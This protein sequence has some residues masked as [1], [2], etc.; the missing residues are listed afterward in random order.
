MNSDFTSTLTFQ[1]SNYTF[2][3]DAILNVNASYLKTWLFR[4]DY[5]LPDYIRYLKGPLSLIHI[6]KT[7]P[8]FIIVG[9]A[10]MRLKGLEEYLAEGKIKDD[11]L[12]L[13]TSQLTTFVQ[14]LLI[15]I[16]DRY[17]RTAAPPEY[18]Y[19]FLNFLN[20]FNQLTTH[21]TNPR[22]LSIYLDKVSVLFNKIDSIISL[23]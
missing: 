2:P 21:Y 7:D 9:V 8:N 10:F 15:E 20:Q 19:L 22:S 1:N 12:L 6:L 4:E 23:Q 14:L 16:I 5:I 11:L 17:I 18:N 13:I 3:H